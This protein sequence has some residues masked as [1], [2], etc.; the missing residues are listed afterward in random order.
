[1][2][3]N[4]EISLFDLQIDHHSTIYLKETAKWARF[5]AILGFIWC[6]LF[7]I[8]GFGMMATRTASLGNSAYATGY[9]IGVSFGYMVVALIYFFPCLYL[10]NFA[11]KMKT[12]LQNNDQEY[13]N[14]SLKN[15]KST[16]RYLGITA[17]VGLALVVILVFFNWYGSLG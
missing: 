8:L 10:F 15:L 12:A 6:G 13:L 4:N 14:A 17:I 16:F 1:M 7:V 2:E 11:R 3:A 9:A 5:L